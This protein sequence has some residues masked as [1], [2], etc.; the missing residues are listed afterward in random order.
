M[1][2]TSIL[3]GLAI[4]WLLYQGSVLIALG[5]RLSAQLAV[6]T[7]RLGELGETL[8]DLQT[9]VQTDKRRMN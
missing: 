4:M 3:V 9:R 5:R 6:L 2:T 1:T 7:I 8:E